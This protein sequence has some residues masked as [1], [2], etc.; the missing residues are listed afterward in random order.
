MSE[1]HI[2][3]E[4]PVLA[5]RS[6]SAMQAATHAADCSSWVGAGTERK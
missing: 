1:D 2:R 4:P 3:V 5:E 6:R